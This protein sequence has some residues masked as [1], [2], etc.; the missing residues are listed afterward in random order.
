MC[1]SG[2]SHPYPTMFELSVLWLLYWS[3]SC[4]STP[5]RP[6][7]I[8]IGIEYNAAPELG[9]FSRDLLYT[10]DS[11]TN[12]GTLNAASSA[13]TNKG[14]ANITTHAADSNARCCLVLMGYSGA[15]KHER[16]HRLPTLR[17]PS[18]AQDCFGVCAIPWDVWN[19]QR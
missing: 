4:G 9:S 15:E 13:E 3:E 5:A 14:A 10:S 11:R 2:M 19:M 7:G 1:G 17:R 6:G 12:M 18:D 16:K 8:A